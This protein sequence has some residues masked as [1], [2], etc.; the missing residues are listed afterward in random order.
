MTRA[1]RMLGALACALALAAPA[2]GDDESERGDRRWRATPDVSVEISVVSGRIEIRGWERDELRVSVRGAGADALDI[3][4]DR[5]G[6]GEPVEWVSVRAPGRRRFWSRG[7]LDVEV[8]VDVPRG[9]DV[10]ARIVNG[11][12]EAKD[13]GGRLSLH[14]A[15]GELDVEGEPAEARLETV[16]S[17]IDFRG[18]DSSVDARTVSG[19]VDLRGVAG[20]VSVST[21][22]GSIRVEGG[23]LDRVE[24][25]SMSG[26]VD[27]EAALAPDARADLRSYSGSLSISLPETTSARFDVQSFSGSIESELGNDGEDDRG[28][29]GQPGSGRRVEFEAG[30]GDARVTVDTFSGSVRIERR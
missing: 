13:V 29:L 15:N 11:P 23:R 27:L 1:L 21:V 24:L 16:S 12:I 20:D 5:V 4:A 6:E 25:R 18:R 14:A 30:D 3:D 28:D 8:R 7:G 17:S 19:T 2:R 9:A 10:R 22:S 26:S